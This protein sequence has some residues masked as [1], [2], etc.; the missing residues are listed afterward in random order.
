MAVGQ[1]TPVLDFLRKVSGA[2]AEP[3]DR[4]LLQRFADH[5][6][7]E[8]FAALVRR[9][10]PMVL[11]VCRR[12]LQHS[13]DADDAFQATFLLLVHKAG[14]L[15]WPDGLGPWLHGVARRTAAKLKSRALRCRLR[16]RPL[17]DVPASTC[18][19]L[20]WRDLR[21]V[22]DDAIS[23]LPAKY[24]APFVLCYLEG[25][26]NA[27]AAQHL[28]C[29]P[30]TIA[31]WLSRARDQL[32]ARLSKRGLGLPAVLAA[33][34]VPP[35]LLHSAL[36][37]ARTSQT[38]APCLLAAKITTLTKGIG[39]VM[40]MHKVRIGVVAVM[41][42][43][44]MGTG[45]GVMTYRAPA[46]ESE[47]VQAATGTTQDTR[48]APKIPPPAAVPTNDS[49]ARVRTENFIVEASTIRLAQ[50]VADAAESQRKKQANQ[51]LG[52]E[53]PTWKEPM[54]TRVTIT[55]N[56]SSSATGFAFDRGRVIN[57]NMNLEGPLDHVLANLLPH[58]VT[59]AVLAHHFREPVPRW[60]DEGA[61]MLSEDAESQSGHHR[62]PRELL[63][64]IKTYPLK[65]LL[66]LREYPETNL[67]AFHVL[68]YSVT[69]FL[70]ERKDRPTFL[71]FLKQV[72]NED[73]DKALER[74]YKIA[75]VD[76]LEKAWLEHVGRAEAKTTQEAATKRPPFGTSPYTV[77]ARV[78]KDGT[79][80]VRFRR[81]I[82]Q[83]ETKTVTISK[84][85]DGGATGTT[86]YEPV[87]TFEWIENTATAVP[88]YDTAGKR[89]D[90]KKLAQL[91]EKETPVLVSA[92]GKKVDP[93]YLHVVKEGTVILVPE[94]PWNL[95]PFWQAVV[96]P[97]A[98]I[99]EKPAAPP[100]QGER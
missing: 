6:D 91:L 81:P 76:G 84:T 67:Y 66:A 48:E 30:G 85:A 16:E 65:R 11:G 3:S 44:A 71:S 10:G 21:P 92:D 59:H 18:D 97:Q 95:T 99:G 12:V 36:Q 24:R 52:K 83:Y 100:R 82:T 88:A 34:T 20:Q 75:G 27:Q 96:P 19:N 35:T 79:L 8:A 51:W 56:E 39:Q 17:A 43:S 89:I 32:R 31:T 72:M 64:S 49:L 93:F 14:R 2:E 41:A 86:Y 29:P 69:R 42:L 61:A 53:M 68:S 9:H 45:V 5:G 78:G 7:E 46:N 37:A 4:Q 58:E 70:V 26:T 80:H 98:L 13:H 15:R 74:H 28:G 50:I 63:S 77:L 25:M 57:V 38:S 47:R 90:A 55:A 23:R 62:S 33:V 40:W 87:Q 60:A 1:L 73:W 54:R 94:T 22:L